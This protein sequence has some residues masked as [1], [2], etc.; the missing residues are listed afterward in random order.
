TLDLLG[1][2]TEA[3]RDYR[4][5]L[6]LR[7]DRAVDAAARRGLGRSYSIARARRFHVDMSLADVVAP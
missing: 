1:R 2:R 4:W 6:G 7:A 5:V 3:L